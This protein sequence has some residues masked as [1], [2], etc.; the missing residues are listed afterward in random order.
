[1]RRPPTGATRGP[2]L[3]RPGSGYGRPLGRPGPDPATH[4]VARGYR[5]WWLSATDLLDA[6]AVQGDP[7]GKGAPPGILD[8]HR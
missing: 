6:V 7:V 1:M 2:G 4:A 3:V 8:R 5:H